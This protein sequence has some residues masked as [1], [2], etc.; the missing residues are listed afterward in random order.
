MIDK[1]LA[2]HPHP[3][4]VTTSEHALAL[5]V[6]SAANHGAPLDALC[7]R[8]LDALAT[9]VPYDLAFF[10]FPTDVASPPLTAARGIPP[11]LEAELQAIPIPDY[12]TAQSVRL[13]SLREPLH[14]QLARHGYSNE[15]SF[16]LSADGPAVG[17]LVLAWRDGAVDA[18]DATL[19]EQNDLVN[20]LCTM[21]A[22]A[23]KREGNE[24]AEHL[25]ESWA[26]S[27]LDN[28]PDGFLEADAE[29]RVTYVNDAYL[30]IIGYSREELLGKTIPRISADKVEIREAV[31]KELR[32]RGEVAERRYEI[33]AK[34][35]A[36]KTIESSARALKDAAGNIV[37]IRV[38]LRDVTA[39]A[40]AEEE[41]ARRGEELRVL[42]QIAALLADPI[43][44]REMLQ[45]ALEL[46]TALTGED[47]AVIHLIDSSR[48]ALELAAHCNLE[49]ELL[50]ASAQVPINPELFQPGFPAERARTLWE[51]VL[52][53]K[54]ILAVEN[55][56]QLPPTLPPLGRTPLYRSA[57]GAP[58]GH[59]D[60][61]YG[62]LLVSSTEPYHFTPHDSELLSNIASQLGLALRTHS[63]F[64]TMERQLREVRGLARSGALIADSPTPEAALAEVAVEIKHALRA[65]Y[66]IFHLLRE[67]QFQTVAASDPIESAQS[68]DINAYEQRILDSQQ[69]TVVTDRDAPDVD[70]V[71][72]EILERLRMRSVVGAPLIAR[73]KPLGILFV[74]RPEAG[75]WMEHELRLIESFSQQIAAA[76]E[77][78]RLFSETQEQVRELRALARIGEW[79]ASSESA[80]EALPQAAREIAETLHADYVGFH[81]REGDNLRL[82]AESYDSG[83]PR[84]LPIEHDQWEILDELKTII[85]TNRE[86]DAANAE[87]RAILEQFN[88]IADVGVPLVAR[89]AAVGILYVSQHQARQ[90]KK[91]EVRLMQTF[92]H[93]ISGAL[94]TAQLVGETQMQ[95]R[96]LQAVARVG[97]LIAASELPL[98]TLPGVAAEIAR[99]LH[100]DYVGFHLR[101]GEALHVLT[102][103]DVVFANETLPIQLHQ[104]RI[105]DQAEI[106]AVTDRN[107]DARNDI[108]RAILER[109]GL[110]ADIGVPMVA[111][112]SVLGILYVSQRTARVWTEGEKRLIQ[113]FAQQAAGAL[114]TAN[115]L[116]ER[117]LRVRE[118]EGLA[119][120]NEYTAL[121]LNE[122]EIVDIAL[123][124]VRDV[125]G[126][127]FVSVA[128]RYRDRFQPSRMLGADPALSQPLML[129]PLRKRLI[130]SK[131]LFVLDANNPQVLDEDV[132]HRMNV[133]GLS[134]VIGAPLITV[135]DW[136]GFMSVGYR[137]PH[138]WSQSEQ[139]TV[140]TIANQLAMAIANT[141]LLAEQRDRVKKLTLLSELSRACGSTLSTQTLLETAI[142]QVKTMLDA[143]QVSI[144]LVKDNYL[145]VGVGVGYIH[146][147]LREHPIILD[148]RLEAILRSNEP[149]WLTDL[150]QASDLPESYRERKLKENV[151]SLLMAPMVAD[152]RALG[153]L[154]VFHYAPHDWEQSEIQYAQTIANTVAL[155]LAN[156]GYVERVQQQRAE[157]QATLDSVFSGVLT[158]DADGNILSVNREAEHI[159]GF[160]AREL[161]GK[162][163][164]REGA[165][166]GEDQNDD[167]LVL[168]A[169]EGGDVIFGFAPRS[170]KTAEGRVIPLME[171]AAPL[172]DE[173]GTLR[174]A[175][176]AFWDRSREEQAHNAKL[177]FLTEV[178]HEVGNTLGVVM[179]SAEMLRKPTLRAKQRKQLVEIIAEH[180]D[181]LN[182]FTARFNAF[183][184]D[185]YSELVE[186]QTVDVRS[187][188]NKQ[189]DAHR[190]Q[191][192]D[193]TIAVGG[194]F[195][196]V[197][198]DPRR[199]D[200]V[201]D[202]LLRNALKYSRPGSRVTITGRLPDDNVLELQFHNSG[203]P[204]P[205]EV[206]AHLFERGVRGGETVP[207][208]GV[209]L[210]LSQARV[211]E[212]GGDIRL[213]SSAER[214]TSITITLRRAGRTAP[215]GELDDETE[216]AYSID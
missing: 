140:Q 100:A 28:S 187:L 176:C 143:G 182:E 43:N 9:I 193:R 45:Q 130:E 41:S 99:T 51:Y 12:F 204:I 170:F 102:E 154:T 108:Q 151:R 153:F 194:T 97:A 104:H 27:F 117:G 11:A 55:M 21:L 119:E 74:N 22:W 109:F 162:N 89:K 179:S 64:E 98:N 137:S 203:E 80:V 168:E 78:G 70:P 10:V 172:L 86:Q 40:R 68:F 23:V 88:F 7:A 125:T 1:T 33:K 67:G 212:M 19:E 14:A 181:E 145:T 118:L 113:T 160:K 59:G 141:R 185:K 49:P 213:S 96:E 90:W 138:I 76:L 200:T 146:P 36:I 156:A 196:P 47:R 35:G 48:T 124:A 157:L 5:D 30:E 32:E 84:I 159:T 71:Q 169:M 166:V 39:R 25:G 127:E 62:I 79:I 131:S 110:V 60:E 29:R 82:V 139:R 63:L 72:R 15:R 149:Y 175:V 94:E 6:S 107:V 52:V 8:A 18:A 158:T 152:G 163:W 192:P 2:P 121:L 171:A 214:G 164:V 161:I 188:L 207:G 186:E 77:T 195:A 24:K 57:I 123:D 37:G 87:Q 197:L 73:Q 142:E 133:Y 105:L 50:A 199:L 46:I 81:L 16:L 205:P 92:A 174:G 34:G 210:W 128:L 106:Q 209:G 189:R 115:L 54:K 20:A 126:A 211:R 111:R 93:Q 53:T 198:A 202:N 66:V 56:L 155:A 116:R 173:D 132:R 135:G 129:T 150:E 83:A 65:G 17:L 136:L 206:Q 167:T 58:L 4:N 178:T 183:R 177:D 114:E 191:Y 95:V 75:A 122:Q 38:I 215:P 208:S 85:V 148:E 134:A 103:S 112:R 26:R 13:E 216:T 180:L 69:L 165:R 91:S 190:L 42:N 201:I 3:D 61:I 184:A 144:R 31:W 101:E 44:F 120:L 147:H